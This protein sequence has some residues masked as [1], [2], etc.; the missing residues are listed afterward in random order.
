MLIEDALKDLEETPEPLTTDKIEILL[1]RLSNAIPA[2]ED[3]LRF[4]QTARILAF[5]L[6]GDEK[7]SPTEEDKKD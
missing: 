6:S 7:L 5:E 3:R 2:Q 4:Q 1:E